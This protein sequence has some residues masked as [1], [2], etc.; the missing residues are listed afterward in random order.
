[1]PITVRL[2]RQFSRQS[3]YGLIEAA[4]AID[5]TPRGAVIDFDFSG[6]EFITPDG[7]TALCNLI[8]YLK[9]NG[10]GS[11]F[12]GYEGLGAAI[13]YLDDCGIFNRYTGNALRVGCTG[14]ATTIPY[15]VVSPEES[16]AHLD[17]TVSPWLAAALAVTEE[18]LSAFRAS[19]RELFTNIQDHST[20]NIGGMHIQHFPNRNIVSISVSDF[21][22][23]I[24][25]AIRTRFEIEGDADAINHALIEGVSTR[26]PPRHSGAGLAYLVRSVAGGN[27]GHVNIYSNGGQ[28]VCFPGRDGPRYIARDAPGDYP[29]TLVALDLRTDTIRDIGQ[30]REDLEWP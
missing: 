19:I 17:F 6:L 24:P 5:G 22:I 14:R 28:V 12:V 4:I 15:A 27:R 30:E 11:S 1:M 13:R 8:E 21:G 26:D 2:P 16:H 23:G 25:A 29:G 7:V 3:M 18:S 9:A 20:Q 10:V